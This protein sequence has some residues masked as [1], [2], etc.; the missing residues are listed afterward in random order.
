VVEGI[1]DVGG[2]LGKFAVKVCP[3]QMTRLRSCTLGLGFTTTDTVK[4]SP[5]QF[6]DTGVTAYTTVAGTLEL[7][8]ST[9]DI[10]AVGKVWAT[11]PVKLPIGVIELTVHL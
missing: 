1:I 5:I 3:L 7:L 4:L 9:W 11:A 10:D 2:L 8:V 6:P